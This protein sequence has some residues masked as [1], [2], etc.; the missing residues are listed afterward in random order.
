MALDPFVC[1]PSHGNDVESNPLLLPGWRRLNPMTQTLTRADAKNRQR[2]PA[3]PTLR[4][5]FNSGGIVRNANWPLERGE[6]VVGRQPS[7]PQHITLLGD[8]HLSRSHAVIERRG[9]RVLIRDIESRNGTVVN[10]KMVE[11]AEL[12]DGD[13]IRLSDTLLMVRLGGEEEQ[14]ADIPTLTGISPKVGHL[15]HFVSLIGPTEATAVLIGETGTG[16]G[17]AAR[18]IHATSSR[19]NG[20]FVSVNCAAIP[21]ALAESALF[22]HRAGAFTGAKRD[23]EGYFR[24]AHGGTLFLDEIGDLPE[25]VQPK[26]LHAIEERAAVPVGTTS[27]VP[28]DIR[29]IAATTVNLSLAVEEGRFR[30]DLYARL[31]DLVFQLPRLRDR[32]ED[33]L[34]ILGEFLQ[35][36]LPPIQPG[37]A[38]ALL[39]YH[40]PYNVREL[41]TLATE[42][43]VRGQGRPSLGT[44]LIAHRLV[45]LTAE[46]TQGDLIVPGP[47]DR[48]AQASKSPPTREELVEVLSAQRGVVSEVARVMGRSRKQ[49]YRWL[50][51]HELDPED[52]R[53]S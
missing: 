9:Q 7:G 4:M 53:T 38:E 39:L 49:V 10:G 42:L 13:V 19:R 51:R 27:P 24:A 16:K 48:T 6:T 43:A 23:A 50:E 30:P 40:W 32:R 26:L 31:A 33:V 8:P 52:Y 37:L 34:P 3:G 25:A 21:E 22:G 41:K 35:P 12:Q 46:V 47:A 44:E 14:D 2:R 20:P 18:A 17:L 15:R 36:G 28:C 1:T 29:I 5:L 11:E 45:P